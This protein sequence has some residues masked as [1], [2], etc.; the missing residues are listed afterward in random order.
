MKHSR[1]RAAVLLVL[2]GVGACGGDGT[3]AERRDR[4]ARRGEGDIVI[5]A[6]WPWEARQE[7]RFGD[8]MD[9][10][11]EQVNAAG[12][13]RGRRL[14]VVRHDDGQSVNEGRLVAQRIAEDPQVMA[15]VG[16]LQSYV[17]VPAAA[18][19]DLS[20]LVLLAP[21]STDAELTSKGYTRTFRGTFTDADV[22]RAMAD[23][24]L[25]QQYRRIA[26][27]YVRSN[28]GR[29]LANAFEERAMASGVQI[30]AR[31]SYD[32]GETADVRSFAPTLRQWSQ[33]QIDAVFLAGEVPLAGT[34]I[35]QIREAGI[36]SPVLG[37][38]AMSSPA[39]LSV[40]GDAVEGTVVASMFHPGEPR[41]QVRTFVEQFRARYGADPDP[42]SALGYDA[43][44]LL[45]H[46]MSQAP[47]VAP[48]EV[49][50]SLHA[51]RDWPGVTGTFS[52][53]EHGNLSGRRIVKMVVRDGR[54][55][56]LP[57]PAAA[58]P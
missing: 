39:L 27:Y 12:G 45:A 7:V 51:L 2:L 26:I 22:G 5:A 49:A 21:A 28:Y 9:L 36:R 3:P 23:Y 4:L 43:V 17:T 38:D 29:A 41:P 6:A 24:A 13:I 20:G 48:A 14:R 44:R 15:V 10:A 58:A 33:L 31:A 42:G 34:L 53:D 46:A 30:V 25:A 50:T 57:E 16:H 55:E 8:G 40:G 37:G 47:S 32:G 54:F 56:Y 1:S 11:V 52:F 18:V 35:R 19:Y